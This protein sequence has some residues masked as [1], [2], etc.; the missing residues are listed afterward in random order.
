M[1]TDYSEQQAELRR[2][3]AEHDAVVLAHNY[4]R[5]EVQDAADHV[6]DSLELSRIAAATS[7]SVILFC[8]VHFMAETA[9]IL[10][11]QKTVLIPDTHAGCPMADMV[12]AEGLRKLKA[13][14]PEALVVA[15]VNT[16]AAVKAESDVC[17]TSANA[18][19][20]VNRLPHD[21]EIIFVPDKNLGDWV[22]KQTGR[23]M[24]LWDGFCHVHDSISVTQILAR[25]EE[26]VDAKVLAHPECTPAVLALADVVTSTSG[27]L[28]YPGE[29]AAGTQTYIIATETGLLHR[30]NQLYPEKRFIAA[31]LNAVCPNMKKTTLEKA[32]QALAEGI[33]EVTVP[34]RT[35]ERAAQA[36]ARMIV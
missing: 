14:H 3:A 27:M 5:A 18:V 30:L 10:A 24:I 11:P 4:Q 36:V 34:P 29:D 25:R 1:A 33:N 9:H 32:I 15:Y 12:T 23:E 31:S 7:E 19:A 21:R 6:G 28:R 35:R 20:V 13:Q 2:L 8:G 26:Y 17:C 22:Q 16:S